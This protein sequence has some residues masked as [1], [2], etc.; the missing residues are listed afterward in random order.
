MSSPVHACTGRAQEIIDPCLLIFPNAKD[1]A[2]AGNDHHLVVN[3]L[4][5]LGYC[6]ELVLP[7]ASLGLN[8]TH[9][10]AYSKQENNLFYRVTVILAHVLQDLRLEKPHLTD[11]LDTILTMKWHCTLHDTNYE[12]AFARSAKFHV[13]YQWA[14]DNFQEGRNL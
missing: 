8:R 4:F 12:M 3:Y 1:S 2:N 10:Y 14:S 11:A 6:K 5:S 9:T 13:E 7:C